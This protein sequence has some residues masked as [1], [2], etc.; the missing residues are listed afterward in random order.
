MKSIIK[1]LLV[2][3]LNTLV[4]ASVMFL[5]YNLLGCSYWISSAFNYIAGGTLSFFLNKF[6]TFKNKEKSLKQ[7]IFFALSV[8][9]CYLIAYG[10]AKPLM[11]NIL[12]GY[13]VKFQE[14]AA[15]L[16]GMVIY[17][18]LNFIIQK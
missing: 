6:F 3:V 2:G 7:V 14:N 16:T 17:T 15:L 8:A 9:V 11:M 12:S 13:S 1:F 4:G 5:L 10:L 18:G